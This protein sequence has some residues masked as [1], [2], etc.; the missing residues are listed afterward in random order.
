MT[1]RSSPSGPT[2][3]RRW[4]EPYLT[5][6]RDT[7][8]RDIGRIYML[9]DIT[10]RK[11]A[12]H[13]AH[14]SEERY[15]S[16]FD[17]APIA[18][19]VCDR[20]AVIHQYNAQAVEL[21]GREPTCGVEKHC[22]STRLWL[23]DGTLLPHD[24]SPVVDVLRTG[25]PVHNVE[26]F[27]ERPDGSRLLVLVN[28]A[29]IK[30]A[31]GEVS[32]AITSFIDITERKRAE[33]ELRQA[34]KRL[35]FVMDS[36]PQKI[37]TAKPNGDV[38]YFNPQWTEFTGLPFEQIRDWG[39]TQFI[40]PD[41]VAENVRVWQQSVDTGEPFQFEHRFRRADGEYR[42]HISRALPMRDAEGR[43]VMWIGSSTDVHEQQQT[44]NKLRQFAADLSEA[45]RRKNEF[46]AM[47]AHELR[48]P[49]APIRN[50]A[51]NPAADGRQRRDGPIGVRDDG[52]PGRPDGAA[53]GRPARREPHQPGQDRA[54][55]GAGRAGVGREPRRRSRPP[56][57]ASAR[58]T[59]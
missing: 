1:S 56:A 53:G 4:L 28:F 54:P 6:L 46:L 31:R 23:P 37:F 50:A 12:E 51:A 44:A 11:Q 10:E 2:A 45:D 13:A 9:V 24:Q 58:S 47:L 19:F 42:W 49:L 43:I 7:E 15:R 30:N 34:E 22:G 17:S 55:Q 33:E 5:P 40:H 16:L 41:D 20:N 25:V 3:R 36:M 59:T 14:E 26:V 52:A 48:N 29:A 35:R 57:G 38:D 32:G 21:W 18:V 27:I 8:G 39:W